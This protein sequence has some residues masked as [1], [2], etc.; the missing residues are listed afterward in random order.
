MTTSLIATNIHSLADFVEQALQQYADKPAYHC[1]GQTLTFGQIDQKSR[2]LAC[3]LQQKTNLKS[4]DIIAI[5]L[6]NLIQYPIAVYAALRMGL[7]I[8]NTNPLYTPREM[9]HQLKNSGAK[10][11]IILPE[12]LAKLD[13]IKSETDIE[14]VI[15]TS[16]TGLISG[17]V[18][19]AGNDNDNDNGDNISFNQAIALGHP[20]TLAPRDALGLDAACVLQYTGGTTGPS[21]G[22]ILTH[23]SILSNCAQTL[24]RISDQCRLTK[25]ILV[26]PLPV[27]HIYAFSVSLLT[28]FSRGNLSILIP[29]P[30]D[31]DGFIKAI[32]PFKFTCFAAI[33]TLLV[34]L[35][36]KPAFKALD[37]S[38]LHFTL[39]G[40]A[41]LTS[42]AGDAWLDITGCSVSEG[43]GLSEASPIVCLN[44]P[45]Q[46]Q[47]GTVGTP[48]LETEIQ[49]SVDGKP[50]ADGEE[51]EILVK[52]PQIMAG[53]W[54]LP[55]ETALSM[56]ADGFFKTGD[57]GIRLPD[58]HIKIVDRLKDMII[59]SGFNV[60]PN[61][62]E[63]VLVTHRKVV[64]AAV[65]GEPDE[66]TGEAVSCFITVNG[67][68]DEQDIIAHCRDSL[69]GYKVPKK[70]TVL[71]ALPKSTVGKILRKELR[72][73][74]S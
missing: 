46:E 62:V 49:L 4:G 20:L 57:I 70:V 42:A 64:E 69:T 56:T 37:F 2:A 3:Y 19:E 32:Q 22:A 11:I 34:A 9:L 43:Y 38:A 39:A 60:Y 73:K 66:R 28:N 44:H 7:I 71:E 41:A 74:I 63:S 33:N 36:Q 10:A 55:A 53:Y 29:N 31:I 16:P 58:G 47:L 27:Y 35:C 1:L 50:V 17:V 23:G 45:G 54:Q 12:L 68:V 18:D 65:I 5:Q 51:G 26:C 59:V 67:P 40:G 48:L 30:S 14:T 72:I 24:E 52:G 13:A 15:V 21:K 6:P 61:E 8:V 25:E